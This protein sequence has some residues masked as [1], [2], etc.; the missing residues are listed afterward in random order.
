MHLYQVIIYFTLNQTK[1]LY[2]QH[3]RLHLIHIAFLMKIYII[4]VHIYQVGSN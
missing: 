4:N 1:V 3:Y 2:I